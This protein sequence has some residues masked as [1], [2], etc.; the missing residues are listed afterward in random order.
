MASAAGQQ[1]PRNTPASCSCLTYSSSCVQD[2]KHTLLPI[3]L[4]LL[5]K[6]QQQKKGAFLQDLFY[7]KIFTK[8]CEAMNV[9][10][11]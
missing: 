3:D 6:Q 1:F 4:D 7:L 8:S 9:C 10:A 2:F 11:G 5:L